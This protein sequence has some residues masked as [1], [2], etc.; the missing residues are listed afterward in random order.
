MELTLNK[1]S[2]ELAEFIGIMLGDGNIWEK[3]GGYYYISVAGD[4]E[5]DKDYL[6]NYVNPLFKKLFGKKM[7][8]KVSKKSK[9]MHL[10]IGDK[11]IVFTLKHFG[12]KSGNKKK[13]NVSI[14]LWIFRDKEYLKACLR[15]LIDTDGSVCPITGRNYPYIW[16]SSNILNIRK[17]FGVGMKKLGFKTSKWKSKKDKP[18]DIYIGNKGDIKKYI[19]TISF[20]NRRHLD[21]LMPR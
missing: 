7:N 12:L 21:K 14:P 15:G 9:S 16:F 19:E 2:K 10:Y 1:K 8:I 5:K 18:S 4:S 17:S 6:E 11:N 3:E 13:N 20:K